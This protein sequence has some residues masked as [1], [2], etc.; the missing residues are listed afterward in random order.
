M[1]DETPSSSEAPEAPEAPAEASPG[2][3]L[4]VG[5]VLSKA[6]TA[7][8]SRL[9]EFLI[10]AV[11]FGV[12]I[13]LIGGVLVLLLAGSATQVKTNQAG[14]VVSG[15][16]FLGAAIGGLIVYFI[17]ALV[18]AVFVFAFQTR[19]ALAAVDGE[20]DVILGD[21]LRQAMSRIGPFFGWMIAVEVIVVIGFVLCFI[22]GI[23]AWFL[24]LLVPF[25]VIEGRLTG[26]PLTESFNAVKER[27]SELLLVY[28]VLFAIAAV[29]NLVG[30]AVQWIPIIGPIFQMGLTFV[31][32]GFSLC[33]IAEVYRA[34][35]LGNPSLATEPRAA[36]APPPP[37]EDEDEPEE[38]D[39]DDD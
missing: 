33:A 24:L 25:I 30:Y 5:T 1:S 19:I 6:W 31:I 4:D 17:I 36:T 11:A 28:L 10:I 18:G 39:G 3:Q 37:D 22:P 2:G 34:T 38:R 35:S 23:I 26:N 13:G 12:V 21:L 29:A 7:F 20:D 16:G 32:T 8:M 9:K 14:Q 15:G 27:W